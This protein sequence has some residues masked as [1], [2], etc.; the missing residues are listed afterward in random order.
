M[1]DD[2][3]LRP[4]TAEDSRAC[5]AVFRASLHDLLRRLGYAVRD[6]DGEIAWPGFEILFGHLAATAGSWWLAEDGDGTAL[7]Y[8]RTTLRGSLVELTEFFVRPD[9][10]VAGA[11][12]AL[13]ERAFPLGWGEHRAIIATLDAPA[14]ALYLRFGVRHQGTAVDVAGRPGRAEPGPGTEVEEATVDVVLELEA[15]ALGHGRPEEVGFVTRTRPGVVV[16]RGGRPVGYAYLPDAAGNAGPIAARRPEDLPLLLAHVE[17]AGHEQGLE[18][19]ELTVPLAAAEA[20]DWLLTDRRFRIDP[21]Y[22]LLLADAPWARF[23][24]YLPYNPCFFL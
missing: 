10:R 17:R 15:E 24:R 20:V 13:L 19:L 2:L 14:V 3:T 6:D 5:F 11:G 9:A 22:T 21:F 12:R 8:A 1:T 16:R 4:A 23:D 18:R 7:G